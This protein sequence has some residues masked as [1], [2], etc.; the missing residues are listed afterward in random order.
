MSNGTCKICENKSKVFDYTVLGEQTFNCSY[1]GKYTLLENLSMDIDVYEKKKN[2]FYKISS[3]VYEQNNKF[4]I[5]PIIDK[6]KIEQLLEMK[7]KKIK[8]KFDLMITYLSLLNEWTQLD[9]KILVACWMKNTNELDILI[10]KANN[11]Y[12]IEG[13]FTKTI[14]RYHYPTFNNLTFDGLSYLESLDYI[15]KNSKNIF[16]AFNFESKLQEI[17]NTYLK[18]AIEKE[19]FNYIVVNQDN[20]EHNKSINDEIIANLKSSR[21]IIAD[22]TNH[23]NSVYFEAGYA[24]GINIPIIWTCQEGHENDMSF[25]TRQFP[26]IIWKSKDDLVKQVIDRIKVIL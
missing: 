6:K 11:E 19:G 24:M 25:D 12:L 18:T 9:N 22:F 10:K 17:F 20:V 14:D 5:T 21:I 3:Y 2:Y 7:D 8:E 23:R 4:N 26:H 13:E 15:N 16:V 1:C